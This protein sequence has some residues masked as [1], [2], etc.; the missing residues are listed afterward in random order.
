[1]AYLRSPLEAFPPTGLLPY[2]AR[3]FPTPAAGNTF[4]TARLEALLDL[5]DEASYLGLDDLLA[6]CDEELAGTVP[7]ALNSPGSAFD[8]DLGAEKE[9]DKEIRMGL[10][11]GRESMPRE[12]GSEGA[13]TNASG[14]T[15]FEP[16][17]QYH[18]DEG[19]RRD[20]KEKGVGMGPGQS[21]ALRSVDIPVLL[22]SS[23]RSRTLS[24]GT[25]ASAASEA[26]KERRIGQVGV[27]PPL[28]ASQ[29]TTNTNVNNA[30]A[31]ASANSQ[32][33]GSR[34]EFELGQGY[35][36][37]RGMESEARNMTPPPPSSSSSR[38]RIPNASQLRAASRERARPKPAGNY[39]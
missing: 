1:M 28:S 5:R 24:T 7:L 35:G 2:A 25:N 31:N 14:R 26:R 8:F 3:L 34:N 38:N 4:A 39:F 15:L 23:P 10:G 12:R 17:M 36:R 11:I 22:P 33:N 9:D 19:K 29:S 13:A 18:Q 20:R 32:M 27:P 30:D 16:Q 6:L 37:G 21:P